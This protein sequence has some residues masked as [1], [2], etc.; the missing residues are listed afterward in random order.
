MLVKFV[1][2]S[3]KQWHLVVHEHSRNLYESAGGFYKVNRTSGLTGNK[4]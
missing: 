3:C 1:M 4:P 2:E